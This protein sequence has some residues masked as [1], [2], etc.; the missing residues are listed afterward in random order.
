MILSYLSLKYKGIYRNFLRTANILNI[1]C[2]IA[3]IGT[4]T[5]ILFTNEYLEHFIPF[6]YIEKTNNSKIIQVIVAYHNDKPII[7]KYDTTK[8]AK[9]YIDNFLPGYEYDNVKYSDVI[10]C[11]N[12]IYFK[13]KKYQQ[14]H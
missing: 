5:V 3:S 6:S 11:K 2:M 9:N 12:L 10:C 8:T 1:L 7:K 14:R 13:N 4:I